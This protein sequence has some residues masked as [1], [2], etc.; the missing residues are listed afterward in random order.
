MAWCWWVAGRAG[1]RVGGRSGGRLGGWLVGRASHLAGWWAEVGGAVGGVAGGSGPYKAELG[2]GAGGDVQDAALQDGME[3]KVQCSSI[4]ACV[5]VCVRN[6]SLCAAPAGRQLPDSNCDKGRLACAWVPSLL[7]PACFRGSC[8]ALAG[9]REGLAGGQ[10]REVGG[11]EA[12]DRR[13][14]AP[15]CMG[16]GQR[17]SGRERAERW[18]ARPNH[19]RAPGS[20]GPRRPRGLAGPVRPCLELTPSCVTVDPC[21]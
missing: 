4:C 7:S 12:E 17:P 16:A 14:C 13:G 1:G 8:S 15:V 21:N 18:P 5:C 10:A 6:C 11:A 2:V 3:G 20:R 19:P 9:W